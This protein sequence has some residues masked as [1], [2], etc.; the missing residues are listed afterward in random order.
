M[1]PKIA[2]KFCPRC[3]QKLQLKNESL[4]CSSCGFHFYVNPAPTNAVL[5][6]NEKKEILLVKRKFDPKKGFWDTAGGFLQPN[7]SIEDSVKREI[8]E[9]LGVDVEMTRIIGLYP[10]DYLFQDIIYPTINILVTAKIISGTL[11]A[12]DDAEEFEF[13]PREKIL[14]LQFAFPWIKKGIEDYL[15]GP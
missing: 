8:F 4:Q 2:F 13:F 5:I 10:D 15:K 12:G 7:E 3:A 1:D 9:E 14:Y 6:E 11:Q